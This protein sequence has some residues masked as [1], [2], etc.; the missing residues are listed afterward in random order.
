MSGGFP[1]LP[2]MPSRYGLHNVTSY[3]M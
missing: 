2:S 1:L 3:H